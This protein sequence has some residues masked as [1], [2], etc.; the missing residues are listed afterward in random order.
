[1]STV[2]ITTPVTS[3]TELYDAVARAMGKNPD[4]CRY[5]CTKIKCA[6]NFFY[7]IEEAYKAKGIPDY[8]SAFG[9]HWV[10][11]GPKAVEDFKPGTVEIEN[12]FFE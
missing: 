8:K 6:V 2:V 1:M 9:M 12:G 3:I 7:E 5:N 11:F 10:C 4:T